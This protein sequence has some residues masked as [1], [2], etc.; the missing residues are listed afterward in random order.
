MRLQK[1]AVTAI[2]IGALVGVALSL[3]GA[4]AESNPP[5]GGAVQPPER[6][7]VKFVEGS[8][9]RSTNDR[10]VSVGA[11]DVTS[12][13]DLLGRYPGVLVEPLFSRPEAA[14]TLDKQTR[15][16]R[17]GKAQPDK[18]LWFRLTPAPGTDLDVLATDLGHLDLVQT[19]YPEPA[20]A[21]QPATPSFVTAQRYLHPASDGIDA[22]YAW[23][24]PGGSGTN[25]RVVDIEYSWNRAHEDLDAAYGPGI[26]IANGTPTDP[27]G[28][29]NHGTA[30]LGELIGTKDSIGITGI[31]HGARVGLVNAYNTADGYDL[32]DSID[33]AAATLD[34]GDVI[35]VEQQAA[36]PNGCDSNTQVGCVPIEWVN[37][38]YDAITSATSAGVIVVEAAGNGGENLGDSGVYGSPFPAGRADSGAIIV[39]A[40]AAPGCPN[41]PRSRLGLST[42]G[43]RVDLQGWGACVATTGYGDLQG[44]TANK[45][46]TAGFSGTSSAS[47]MVAGAA[48]AL[49]SVAQGQGLVWTPQQI[50]ARLVLT[51]TPQELAPPANAGK[52]GPL[53]DLRQAVKAFVPD[54]NPGGPY[55][56]RKGTAVALSGAGST[57]P[58]GHKLTY[59]W[60]LDGDGFDDGIST[61][62]AF[63][64]VLEAGT[65]SVGLRVTDEHGASDVDTTTV[66]VTQPPLNTKAVTE[67][68][69]S[70]TIGGATVSLAVRSFLLFGRPLLY[71]GG[72]TVEN[73]GKTFN[74]AVFAATIPRYGQSGA[75]LTAFT[76]GP[77]LTF[78]LLRIDVDDL[79]AYGLGADIVSI[80]PTSGTL[81]W[82]PIA[83]GPLTSGDFDVRSL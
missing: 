81:S 51:G 26:L 56:T 1:F 67:V 73:A 54:S 62:V 82:T 74:L 22:D 68:I 39:G 80:A 24:V 8:G 50:R 41:P 13:N 46:Y 35:L 10:F 30:V 55:T 58:N 66:T 48:G 32:A 71:L 29:T 37:A 27:F 61:T 28:S 83:S 72:G 15:E 20:L 14:L 33:L 38:Y 9:I 21:P 4:G 19:A 36:G 7:H 16:A 57:D 77:G 34:P 78:G 76:F 65:Y 45:L 42:F 44:G 25:V 59:A 23:T 17:S 79:S 64:R 31:L 53:P 60:D 69:G 6:V 70:G 12:L 47:A 3:Q 2:I 18:T 75:T 43:P 49:S 5:E 52:I 11:V 40:G 63:D